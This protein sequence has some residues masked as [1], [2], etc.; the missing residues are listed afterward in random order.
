MGQEEID[1][2]EYYG[3]EGKGKS[4]GKGSAQGGSQCFTC[5]SASHFAKDCPYK[6]HGKGEKEKEKVD[7][8]EC[9]TTAESIGL[10]P[11]RALRQGARA[12]LK[13]NQRQSSVA[14]GWRRRG[15]ELGATRG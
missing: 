10:Q 12:K 3:Y 6:G 11:K 14:A 7:F 5:G 15:L 9:A 8:E 13:E 1:A 4:Q 2:I